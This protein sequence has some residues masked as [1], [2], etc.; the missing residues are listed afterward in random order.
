MTKEISTEIVVFFHL[1]QQYDVCHVIFLFVLFYK[2]ILAMA[3]F[4]ISFRL[5]IYHMPKKDH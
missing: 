5:I 3:S 1:L 4:S 2:Q